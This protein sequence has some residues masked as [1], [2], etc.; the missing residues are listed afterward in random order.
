MVWCTKVT[1]ITAKKKE[2]RT[3]TFG[4]TGLRS[5]LMVI[6]AQH[7]IHGDIQT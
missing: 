3:L 5:P 2:A 6:G 1:E 4:E 7:K